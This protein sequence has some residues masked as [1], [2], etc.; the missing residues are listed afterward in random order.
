MYKNS[1][2]IMYKNT[3]LSLLIFVT[4]FVVHS[5]YPILVLVIMEL[6]KPLFKIYC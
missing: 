4:V 6:E 5:I 3:Y 1:L 2:G